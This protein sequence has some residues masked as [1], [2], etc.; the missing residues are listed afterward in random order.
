METIVRNT[1]RDYAMLAAGDTVTVA[2]SGGA[3]ST[4]LL[5]VLRALAP[6][7]G[8]RLRAAHFHHGLRGTEADR[9]AE[10]CRALCLEHGIPFE[11]GRGDAAAHAKAS[12]KSL[13]DA[14]RELRYAFLRSVSPGK[15]AT[16]HNADDNAETLLLHLIRG[17]GLRGLG[18]I[19]PVRENVIRPLLRVERAQILDWLAV[20]GQAYVEDSSNA[21][22]DCRRNRLRHRVLPLLREENPRLC[23]A[24]GAAA[25]LLREEDECLSRLAAAAE[26]RCTAGGRL[27]CAALRSE[28]PVLRRRILLSRLRAL[29]P[30]NPARV[31]VQALE[32][33]VFSGRPSARIRLP[34]GLA[35]W[36]EYD[37]LCFG[38]AEAEAP[39]AET[40][41]VLP[42]TTVLPGNAGSVRC[43]VTKNSNFVQ[44]NL[45]TYAL[46][47]DMIS[48]ADLRLRPRRTGDRLRLGGM[49]RSVKKL[50]I[51][52]RIPARLRDRLPVLACGETV[53]AV[54]GLG[55][56]ERFLADGDAPAVVFEYFPGT[57]I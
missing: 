34:G 22:D 18:G 10:F 40:A 46:K 55:A 32:R 42:G 47:C 17:T 31:Y 39:W 12:G 26:A 36:R 5:L 28:E 15:I 27:S 16:A 8:I 7:L 48:E 44:K 52:R 41:P 9:D 45:T 50:M 56:D 37:A 25:A 49:D 14:A 43:F 33:L 4:A 24:M 21:L 23:A 54:F 38:P 19:P 30:E 35:A 13:E 53:A 20:R 29:G 11:L 1:I 2:L 3:D 6:E 51:D 57:E